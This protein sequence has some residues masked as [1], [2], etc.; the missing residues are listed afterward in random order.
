MNCVECGTR[1]CHEN[2]DVCWACFY[3]VAP[4]LDD[5]AWTAWK[6]AQVAEANDRFLAVL[7]QDDYYSP[8]A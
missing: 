8:R 4:T 2:L 1:G 6:S 7:A 5:A 3:G